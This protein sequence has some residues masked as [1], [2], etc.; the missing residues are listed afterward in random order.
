M[1]LD[2]LLC[3]LRFAK[4]RSVAQSWIGEGHIRCN[5]ERVIAASRAV[6]VGDVLTLPLGPHIA[7]IA[8]D[9]LPERRGPPAEARSHYRQ[10]NG[11]QHTG[12]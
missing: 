3:R 7:V 12:A 2:L 6:G 1:R 11:G 8:I 10:L 5:G 4:S 9:S